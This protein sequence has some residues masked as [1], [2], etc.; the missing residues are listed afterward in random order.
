MRIF[1]ETCRYL[2]LAISSNIADYRRQNNGNL[3][4]PSVTNDDE[5]QILVS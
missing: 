3:N 4:L 2:G 5:E 1:G